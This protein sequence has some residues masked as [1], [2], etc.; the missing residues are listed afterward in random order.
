MKLIARVD[1]KLAIEKLYGP[2]SNGTVQASRSEGDGHD[3]LLC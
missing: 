3:M 2:L 1:W